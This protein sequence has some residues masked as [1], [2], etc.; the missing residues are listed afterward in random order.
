MH[1]LGET[2]GRQGLPLIYR[3]PRQR[4][5][6]NVSAYSKRGTQLQTINMLKPLPPLSSADLLTLHRLGLTPLR[7]QATR[8]LLLFVSFG[9]V[10]QNSECRTLGLFHHKFR[11]LHR[12]PSV[13]KTIYCRRASFALRLKDYDSR[14]LTFGRAPLFCHLSSAPAHLGSPLPSAQLFF[15]H[16]ATRYQGELPPASTTYLGAARHHHDGAHH[17]TGGDEYR[18][19]SYTSLPGVAFVSFLRHSLLPPKPA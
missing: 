1:S 17:L 5:A 16:V 15:A 7:G 18:S 10:P 2:P 14:S 19:D 8:P 11:Q 9:K 4:A 6:L 3:V 12:Q 13:F